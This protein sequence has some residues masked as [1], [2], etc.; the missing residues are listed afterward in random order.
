MSKKKK[1]Y[2]CDWELPPT[3]FDCD[4]GCG[5]DDLYLNLRLYK[6]EQEQKKQALINMQRD[7]L[8]KISE[9]YYSLN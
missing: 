6:Q 3:N 5:N 2:T 1:P 9:F 4:C 8:I 7:T